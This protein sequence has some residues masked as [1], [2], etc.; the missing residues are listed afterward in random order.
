MVVG[1][2]LDLAPVALDVLLDDYRALVGVA[3]HIRP[4]ALSD[5][6]GQVDRAVVL[7]DGLLDLRD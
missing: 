3:A 4:N 6:L 5:P 1:E 7:S 2:L